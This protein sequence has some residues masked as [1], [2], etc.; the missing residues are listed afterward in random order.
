MSSGKGLLPPHRAHRRARLYLSFPRSAC[1]PKRSLSR[2]R[3]SG[4]DGTSPALT[5]TVH[6]QRA[7]STTGRSVLDEASPEAGGVC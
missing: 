6:S 1:S 3:R 2:A 4:R 7:R 5:T